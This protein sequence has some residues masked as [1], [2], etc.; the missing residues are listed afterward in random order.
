MSNPPDLEALAKMET[1][2]QV[3]EAF[4]RGVPIMDLYHHTPRMQRIRDDHEELYRLA[5]PLYRDERKHMAFYS[6]W[7]DKDWKCFIGSAYVE[8][9]ERVAAHLAGLPWPPEA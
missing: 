6:G 2:E 5:I 3:L 8:A 7:T 4:R 1:H 9:Q